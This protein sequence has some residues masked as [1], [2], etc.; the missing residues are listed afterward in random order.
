MKS[1]FYPLVD[2]EVFKINLYTNFF[3]TKVS[4]S[5]YCP[6]IN[7]V[8]ILFLLY[9]SSRGHIF[10]ILYRKCLNWSFIFN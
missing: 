4:D 9:S 8:G 10:Y 5:I 7:S 3:L 1:S 6:R 2:I